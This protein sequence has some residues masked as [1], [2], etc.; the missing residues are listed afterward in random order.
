LNVIVVVTLGF[1]GEPNLDVLES[2]AWELL[3]ALDEEQA[4][5]EARLVAHGPG[6][7]ATLVEPPSPFGNDLLNLPTTWQLVQWRRDDAGADHDRAAA[8]VVVTQILDLVP[9][10]FHDWVLDTTAE[11]L[12]ALEA[13]V[14]DLEAADPGL[15][16]DNSATMLS[17]IETLRHQL[18]A[19]QERRNAFRR[20]RERLY[21]TY[22]YDFP[23]SVGRDWDLGPTIDGTEALIIQSTATKYRGVRRAMVPPD[24]LT[25]W[26]WTDPG[27][28]AA[29][30][31]HLTPSEVLSRVPT[32]FHGWVASKTHEALQRAGHSL[33][34]LAGRTLD[35]EDLARMVRIAGHARS[36][37]GFSRASG[38]APDEP[39]AGEN[40]DVVAVTPNPDGRFVL[41][42]ADRWEHVL[43]GHPEMVDHVED[44][45]T[46][47]EDPEHREP[48][49]R[50]GRERYFRRGGPERWLRVVVE[51]N[52]PVDHVVT[53]FPQANEPER[54]RR[55]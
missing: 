52:G 16:F 4:L 21:G 5:D 14:S 20:R 3:V 46:T 17:G 40:S 35:A 8:P 54:W 2:A 15:G 47:I 29:G 13:L 43:I 32:A 19:G 36:L 34:E 53:T 10:R 7:W 24:E 51:M 37:A 6:G 22:V 12:D 9:A 44:V 1:S 23:S 30:G 18:A 33:W 31:E 49:V 11:A 38:L 25:P 45:I 28:P 39:F 42:L 48:D 27:R 55:R 50:V 26:R 41:L